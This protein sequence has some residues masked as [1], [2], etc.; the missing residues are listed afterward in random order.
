M[1]SRVKK[2]AHA[3]ERIGLAMAG[4]A[5]GLFVA[6]HV[7]SS[8]AAFTSEDIGGVRLAAGVRFCADS[9][10]GHR[11]RKLTRKSGKREPVLRNTIWANL[12]IFRPLSTS[13]GP[14]HLQLQ[15]LPPPL[16]QAHPGRGDGGPA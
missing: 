15:W 8:I 3:L 16:S 10:R 14:N 9:A 2:I 12:S 6:A 11:S 4:A 13:T 7:G 1:R 5:S